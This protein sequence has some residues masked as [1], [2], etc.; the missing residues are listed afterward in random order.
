MPQDSIW[1]YMDFG[2]ARQELKKARE[3]NPELEFRLVKI[4]ETHTFLK[5]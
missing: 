2:Y 3:E 4:I 5:V 1:Q